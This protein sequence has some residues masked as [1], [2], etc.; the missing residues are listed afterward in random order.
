MIVLKLGHNK[1]EAFCLVFADI[2][3]M[4]FNSHAKFV[5]IWHSRNSELIIPHC[6]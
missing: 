3:V 4:K 6:I 1:A 2:T 5:K